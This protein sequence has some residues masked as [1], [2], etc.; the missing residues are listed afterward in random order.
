MDKPGFSWP[1]KPTSW[2]FKNNQK[3]Y[4]TIFFESMFLK[5][6][7]NFLELVLSNIDASE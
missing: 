7:Y 3:M 2:S 1:P 4:G 5:H 6:H